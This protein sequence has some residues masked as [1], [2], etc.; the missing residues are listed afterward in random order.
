MIYLFHGNDRALSRNRLKKVLSALQSKRPDATTF[1]LTK[2]N[3]DPNQFEELLS[4]QGLFD[5]K[6]I[7]V[8]DSLLTLPETKD[9][10]LK[11]FKIAQESENVFL[12]IEEKVPAPIISSFQ[13]IGGLSEE[14][15]LKEEKSRGINPFTFTDAWARGN[16]KL[17]WVLY[18]NFLKKMTPE[19]IHGALFWQAK[20]MFLASVLP[21]AKEAKLKPFVF[22]KNAFL[23]KKR[24]KEKITDSLRSLLEMYHDIRLEGGDL[25]LSLEKFILED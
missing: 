11:S 7:T 9:L 20:T 3:W 14:F 22:Q 17:A 25:S 16:K 24:S 19:E 13:R 10:F 1:A 12:F 23:G 5:K 8:V 15:S 21:G 2:D 6:T 4:G 18:Q